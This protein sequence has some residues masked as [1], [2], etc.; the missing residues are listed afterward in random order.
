M[1]FLWQGSEIWSTS[2]KENKQN[3]LYPGKYRGTAAIKGAC[4]VKL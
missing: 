3:K 4:P 2:N 1:I